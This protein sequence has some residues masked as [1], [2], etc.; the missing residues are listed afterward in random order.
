MTLILLFGQWQNTQVLLEVKQGVKSD[1]VD[2]DDG[3]LFLDLSTPVR[4]LA[5]IVWSEK[6]TVAFEPA[7][8]EPIPAAEMKIRELEERVRKM[9]ADRVRERGVNSKAR[10]L[11][12]EIADIG[13]TVEIDDVLTWKRCSYDVD[14][15]HFIV[16]ENGCIEF[17]TEGSYR[18]ALHIQHSRQSLTA[19]H[20][21]MEWNG[22]VAA[23]SDKANC[24]SSFSEAWG[25]VAGDTLSVTSATVARIFEGTSLAILPAS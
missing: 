3:H 6:A 1:L 10:V 21:I 23:H 25:V 15:E 11:L 5:P 19:Q 20:F 22:A 24:T 8:V 14:S 13:S 12:L 18:V 2:A 17:R 9:T 7:K 4:G 16:H